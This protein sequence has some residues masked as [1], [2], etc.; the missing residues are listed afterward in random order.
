LANV[1]L[2]RL[3]QEHDWLARGPWDYVDENG[4]EHD[5]GDWAAEQLELLQPVLETVR[6]GLHVKRRRSFRAH[7]MLT[8][9]CPKES[10]SHALGYVYE[11]TTYPVYIP[12][13]S[14]NL[15]G[16][17]VVPREQLA[18][19]PT[20]DLFRAHTG[21]NSRA[22][23]R[24]RSAARAVARTDD[25]KNTLKYLGL[26][27]GNNTWV[28]LPSTFWERWTPEDEYLFGPGSANGP[29]VPGTLVL[30]PTKY[31]ADDDSYRAYCSCGR[32][33]ITWG[34]LYNAALDPNVSTLT[35]AR[36]K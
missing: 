32:N 14:A 30:K 28:Q 5:A 27:Q 24:A 25:E 29:T 12:T 1:W 18:K 6:K 15:R 9:Y 17:W 16:D 36:D 22:R 8:V 4:N 13:L 26:H 10:P 7:V 11:T 21:E 19:R 31:T 33:W 34:D 35:A 3:E 23:F 2:E 20:D